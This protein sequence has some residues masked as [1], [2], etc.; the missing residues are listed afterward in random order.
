MRLLQLGV[1][2]WQLLEDW[3]E[4]NP[5]QE[6]AYQLPFRK[7]LFIIYPTD[8]IQTPSKLDRVVL[9]LELEQVW[10]GCFTCN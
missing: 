4:P 2:V 9:F 6:D 10:L 8:V 7:K 5:W 1:S 3:T